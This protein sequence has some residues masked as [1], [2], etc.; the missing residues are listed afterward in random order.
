MKP[1]SVCEIV[2]RDGEFLYRKGSQAEPVPCSA[3]HE[4]LSSYVG[5]SEIMSRYSF[6]RCCVR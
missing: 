5:C 6:V 1:V 2:V 3:S 4:L